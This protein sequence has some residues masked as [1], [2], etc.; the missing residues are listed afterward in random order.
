[1][2]I[3]GII[4]KNHECII[5]ELGPNASDFLIKEFHHLASRRI[6]SFGSSFLKPFKGL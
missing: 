4:V 1:M 6:Y 3:I 5:S 2:A